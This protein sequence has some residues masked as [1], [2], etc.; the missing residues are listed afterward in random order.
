LTAKA[1]LPFEQPLLLVLTRGFRWRRRANLLGDATR[2]APRVAPEE[3][4]APRLIDPVEQVKAGVRAKVEH[5]L[6]C[7]TC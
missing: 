1:T 6:R 2:Q 7:R 4:E 3:E 5:V